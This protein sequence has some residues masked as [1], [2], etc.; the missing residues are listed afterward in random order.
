MPPN[1]TKSELR[2]SRRLLRTAVLCGLATIIGLGGIFTLELAYRASGFQSANQRGLLTDTALFRYHPFLGSVM[3]PNLEMGRTPSPLDGYFGHSA[4]DDADGII[5]RTNNLGFRSPEFAG[6]ADKQP[7]ELRIIITGGSASISWNIGEACT[8]DRHLQR[9]L[10]ERLPGRVIRVFNLGSGTWKSFQELLAVQLYGPALQ[11]DVIIDFSGFNDIA[12]SFHM[13]INRAYV[14]PMMRTAAA[15]HAEDARGTVRGLFSKF[16]LGRLPIDIFSP[17]LVG[18]ANA[19]AELIPE[20]ASEPR[21]G[22]M[23]TQ[24]HAPADFA[25]IAAR[26]DF[27]PHGRQ[28]VDNLIANQKLMAQSAAVMGAQMISALQ[29]ALC[30]RTRMHPKEQELFERYYSR[31]AN[32]TI[33]G[34]LRARQDLSELARSTPNLHFEDLSQAFDDGSYPVFGDEVHFN[35]DGYARLAKRLA[36]VVERVIA[37][38]TP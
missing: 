1:E 32:Y 24:F 12:H 26:T 35:G 14:D 5:L 31:S 17:R 30:M 21:P 28:T 15:A 23:A 37:G 3:P 22:R 38:R 33:Q 20:R 19:A 9:L 7:D 2:L 11:P 29:P 16:L 8:L 4:C 34:Y 18:V 36:V 25:A 13:D 27:D 10:T 6:L